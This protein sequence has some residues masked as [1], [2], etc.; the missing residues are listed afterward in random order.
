MQVSGWAIDPDTSS[1][2]A[3]HFYIDGVGVAKTA[4]QSRPDVAAAYPGSG[5]KHGFSA[6]IPAGSG[7]HL[8]C[9]YAINDAVGNNTLLACRSF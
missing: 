4:D 8:V 5:D 3:V 6:M 7:S 2:I 9:A 1:P